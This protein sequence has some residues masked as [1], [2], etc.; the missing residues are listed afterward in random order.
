MIEIIVEMEQ[1]REVCLCECLE[2]FPSVVDPFRIIK[3]AK[4]FESRDAID[5][6]T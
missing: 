5:A 2:E 4:V 1:L 6:S 3:I